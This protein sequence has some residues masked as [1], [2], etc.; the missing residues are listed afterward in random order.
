M[1]ISGLVDDTEPP[2][3]FANLMALPDS[4]AL[5]SGAKTQNFIV[6]A[7]SG[8]RPTTARM[9]PAGVLHNEQTNTDQRDSSH[10]AQQT[11]G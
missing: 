2:L 1:M 5:N 4:D 8:T 3:Y 7:N 10:N 6:P 11:P 9:T